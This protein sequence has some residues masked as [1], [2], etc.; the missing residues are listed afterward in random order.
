MRC[1]ELETT[2]EQQRRLLDSS[3][4]EAERKRANLDRLIDALRAERKGL[5]PPGSAER[6]ARQLTKDLGM[7][8]G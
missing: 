7:P 4:A 2:Q 3:I 8:G 5:T 1:S 6:V